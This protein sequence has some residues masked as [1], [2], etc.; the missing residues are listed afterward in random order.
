MTAVARSEGPRDQE[1]D[2]Y[3]GRQQETEHDPHEQQYLPQ[4]APEVAGSGPPGG[5]EA[6]SLAAL[7]G[8]HALGEPSL[9]DHVERQ[10]DEEDQEPKHH[11][12][13]DEERVVER[14]LLYRGD[15]SDLSGALFVKVSAST[16]ASRAQAHEEPEVAVVERDLEGVLDEISVVHHPSTQVSFILPPLEMLTMCLPG[17]ATRLREPG[18]ISTTSGSSGSGA[19]TSIR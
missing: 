7:Y 9:R 5:R 15:G 8:R 18:T 6:A 2:R 1:R 12:T 3:P 10:K 14:S 19:R 17:V 4:H 16:S 11:Q 13:D